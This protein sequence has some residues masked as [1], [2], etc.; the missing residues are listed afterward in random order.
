MS[1]RVT[2]KFLQTP[3]AELETY[4]ADIKAINHLEDKFGILYIHHLRR[5]TKEQLLGRKDW[6]GAN[7]LKTVLTALEK[8]KKD[9]LLEINDQRSE[10]EYF[11][12][13]QA[14]DSFLSNRIRSSAVR[15]PQIRWQ[16]IDVRKDPAARAYELLNVS[17]GVHLQEK[18]DLTHWKNQIRPNLPWADNHFE[19]RV[20]RQ[21]LNPG[22]EWQNWPWGRSADNF[23]SESLQIFNHTYQERLWPK[24]AGMT[25]EGKLTDEQRKD[26]QPRTGIRSMYGDLDS[27]V[28]LLVREPTTR[29][30]YIP[31]FF[32]EDTGWGDGGRKPCTLG[33]QFIVRDNR[34]HI[35]YPL[36][37]CDFAHHFRDD[38]YLAIRL[39]LWVLNECRS[40]N[41]RRKYWDDVYPGTYSM[42]IT[43]LHIFE[44]D[45][46]ELRSGTPLA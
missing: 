29:Q 27:L 10:M 5:F 45:Y 42:H 40:R 46:R 38:C 14:V 41:G 44:N 6:L 17:F 32:P 43:S 18:M 8:Y 30:A 13:F 2:E 1:V 4:G 28:D 7:N 23:R 31:L 16:G 20:G 19:E 39:L 36:R 22:V 12:S 21:P 9:C 26:L 34:I 3:I 25:S 24:Y 37:S 33:Y 11:Y 15:V 35:W